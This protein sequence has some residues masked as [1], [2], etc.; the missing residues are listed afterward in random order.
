VVIAK[1]GFSLTNF[2]SITNRSTEYHFPQKIRRSPVI[3]RPKRTRTASRT[4]DTY[5]N[6]SEKILSNFYF[7]NLVLLNL[8]DNFS[9]KTLKHQLKFTGLFPGGR[10]RFLVPFNHDSEQF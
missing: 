7:E 10:C 2:L 3:I 5:S 8:L 6:R 1:K 4:Y 9:L